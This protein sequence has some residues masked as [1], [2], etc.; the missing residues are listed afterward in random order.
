MLRVPLEQAEGGPAV[1]GN[2]LKALWVQSEGDQAEVLLLT[3]AET[4]FVS[5]QQ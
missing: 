5:M 2:V 1:V 3:A 4:K